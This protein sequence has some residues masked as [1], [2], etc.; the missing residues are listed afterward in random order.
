MDTQRPLPKPDQDSVA[1]WE[2]A[3]RHELLL[4]QCS[5]CN[6]FRFYPRCICPYCFSDKFEWRQAAGRGTVYSF[7]IIH[8]APFPAFRDKVP[9]VLA[10]IELTEG[11]RMMTNIL[12]CEPNMVEI[13]MPVEVTFEDVTEEV[14][15]PQF[16]PAKA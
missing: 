6:K 9:Y 12:E 13:G 14:T 2:A 8:R 15:L 10:L 16:R 5:A 11:V 4:Q 7:T 3:R 1:Y